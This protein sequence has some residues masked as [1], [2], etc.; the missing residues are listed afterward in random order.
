LSLKQDMESAVKSQRG[1]GGGARSGGGG[2]GSWWG[3]S[4]GERAEEGLLGAHAES[5]GGV[6]SEQ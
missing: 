4:E 1:G 3:G 5:E 6:G 2:G